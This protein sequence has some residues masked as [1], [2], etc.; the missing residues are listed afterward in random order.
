MHWI[1][2]I[3]CM[4]V[5]NMVALF[6]THK[7][8]NYLESP[9]G[10]FVATAYPET[11]GCFCQLCNLLPSN[12]LSSARL[13]TLNL[14]PCLFWNRPLMVDSSVL[15]SIAFGKLLLSFNPIV[16]VTCKPK[17][18]IKKTATFIV[19]AKWYD[20]MARNPLVNYTKLQHELGNVVQIPTELRIPK[21]WMHP[22]KHTMRALN[23]IHSLCP[24]NYMH[25]SACSPH[26]CN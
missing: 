6:I 19:A 15:L 20:W 5:T 12:I 10:S 25:I 14:F 4:S 8:L 23:S 26:L 13:P 1:V 16:D 24:F 7:Y 11:S 17:S 3:L 2:Q 22:L 21:T 9:L 18:A